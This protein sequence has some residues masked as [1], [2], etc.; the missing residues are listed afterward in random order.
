VRVA[1]D[2]VGMDVATR[3]RIFEP[4]FTTRPEAGGTG[5]GLAIVKTI[6]SSNLGGIDVASEPGRGTI[7]TVYLPCVTPTSEAPGAASATEARVEGHETILLVEDQE[8]VRRV[9]ALGLQYYGYHVIEAVDSVA[10]MAF[11]ETAGFD[12]VALVISDLQMPG[13]SGAQLLAALRARRPELGA[14][15]IS[16]DAGDQSVG[17]RALPADVELLAKPFTPAVLAKKI[18][19]ILGSPRKGGGGA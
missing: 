15:I 13:G 7:F 19:E 5:L 11:A 8:A 1:D 14:L 4:F 9:I 2:G 17:P 10:A 3:R 12:R 16:G 6:V 18:R